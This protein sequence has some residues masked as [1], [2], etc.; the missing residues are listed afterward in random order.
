ML[1]RMTAYNINQVDDILEARREEITADTVRALPAFIRDQRPHVLLTTNG[2]GIDV[3]LAF[4]RPPAIEWLHLAPLGAIALI[5]Q[6]GDRET[7]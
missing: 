1:P 5:D 3:W 6:Y 2:D 7:I 4:G